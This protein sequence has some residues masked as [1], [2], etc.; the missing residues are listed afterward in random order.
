MTTDPP[1]WCIVL[2]PHGEGPP[3]GRRVARLLK[4]ALRAYGLR[5]VEVR[6]DIPA[7]VTVPRKRSRKARAVAADTMTPAPSVLTLG[8]ASV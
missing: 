1:V 7:T 4:A 3:A 6:S 2:I 5:C 8:L